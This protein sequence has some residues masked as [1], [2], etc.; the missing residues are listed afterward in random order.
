MFGTIRKHQKWLWAIII[1]ITIISFVVFFSPN[2][3]LRGTSEG[4]NLG[5]IGGK[6]ITTEQYRID[7]RE[8]QLFYYIHYGGRWPESDEMTRQLGFDLDREVYRRLLI[9]EKARQLNIRPNAAAPAD[10]ITRVFTA[11]TT[12]PF[13]QQAVQNFIKTTLNP[14][15]V[16]AEDFY[17]FAQS[18]VA[19]EQMILTFGLTGR[20]VTPQEAEFLY[21]EQNEPLSAEVVFFTASNFLSRITITPEALATYYTNH[22]A[23]YRIPDRRQVSYV[24]FDMTNFLAEADQQLAQITNL[25]AVLDQEYIRR[26][27]NYYKDTKGNP[28]PPEE[29]RK[30]IKEEER[31]QLALLAARKRANTFLNTL[32]QEAEKEN[33]KSVSTEDFEKFAASSNFVIRVTPP[34]DE[35]AGPADLKVP[36]TFERIAF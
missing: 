29:A 33:K 2:A 30:K 26:G 20:M 11:G 25:A 12:M 17:D 27:A 9:D 18:E 31:D 16:T 10:W 19:R 1:T 21:R 32:F 14:H 4:A 23:E 3:R 35:R 15:H 7:Y 24:K 28:L 8:A 36:T 34:F 6:P 22:Q 5:S 13:N